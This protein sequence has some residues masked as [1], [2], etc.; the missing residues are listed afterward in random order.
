M[1]PWDDG[2]WKFQSN[3]VCVCVCSFQIEGSQE[4]S[5]DVLKK[6]KLIEYLTCLNMLYLRDLHNTL[7]FFTSAL[8]I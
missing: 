1:N 6:I 2:E 8:G 4:I 5:E 3:I 7:S